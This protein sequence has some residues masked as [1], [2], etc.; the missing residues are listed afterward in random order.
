[1]ALKNDI[2]YKALKRV[3]IDRVYYL[4]N[5]VDNS[6]SSNQLPFIVYQVISKTPISTD[7][8]LAI[9]KVTYQITLV[10]KKRSEALTRRLETALIN[11]E[12]IPRLISTYKNDDYSI[13]RVYEVNILSKGGY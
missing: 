3:L 1:M 9:Y 7:N 8:T 2:V 10:T 13:S 6:T 12:L 11:S 5:S 4:T